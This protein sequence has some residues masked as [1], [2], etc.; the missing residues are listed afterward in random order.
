M[1]LADVLGRYR[2]VLG[3]FSTVLVESMLAH[4]VVVRVQAG[5]SSQLAQELDRVLPPVPATE[6]EVALDRAIG[7]EPGSN[8]VRSW[9]RDEFDA[10]PNDGRA[11]AAEIESRI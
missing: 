5:A 3:F 10:F 7:S 11:L 2:V 9:L 6:I 4:R 8:A 1:G